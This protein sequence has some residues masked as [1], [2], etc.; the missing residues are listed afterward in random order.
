M[1]FG[2]RALP[3][4]APNPHFRVE[5][6]EGAPRTP[7]DS[8]WGDAWSAHLM[9]HEL[10]HMIG[11]RRRIVDTG[12]GG[13]AALAW[14]GRWPLVRRHQVLV[15][16]HLPQ[17]AAFADRQVAVEKGSAGPHVASARWPSTAPTG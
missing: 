6:A 4:G 5:L 2:F 12:I 13:E 15:V 17:V 11:A 7:Y 1:H 3:D 9:A 10:G 8:T 14:A 16:T